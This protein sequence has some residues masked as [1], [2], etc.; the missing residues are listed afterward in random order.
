MIKFR[1]DRDQL[2]SS[3]TIVSELNVLEP[4]KSQ[5]TTELTEVP[6]RETTTASPPQDA[7]AQTKHT[8][9]NMPL[10]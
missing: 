9:E 1:E 3:Q 10:N 5:L 2:L 8:S 4:V 6:R 7:P